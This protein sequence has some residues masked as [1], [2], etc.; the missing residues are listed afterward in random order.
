MTMSSGADAREGGRRSFIDS[1]SHFVGTYTTPNDLHIEGRYEGTIECAGALHIAEDADVNAQV[2]AG[3]ISIRGRLQGEIS[4]R[5]RFE[6]LPTGRVQARIV[7]GTIV[8][9]EGAQ[10][11]GEMRMRSD[12]GDVAAERPTPARPESR[13]PRRQSPGAT[14]DV[15]AYLGGGG[16]TNGHGLTDE[17]AKAAESDTPRTPGRPAPPAE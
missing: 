17:A 7:T 1:E 5:G 15:P 6:I 16:R 9:H 11:Q 3:S 12:A 10:Y 4:C 14:T 8:V 13:S 2:S